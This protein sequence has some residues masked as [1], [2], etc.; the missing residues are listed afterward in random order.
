[1]HTYTHTYTFITLKIA[2]LN[3]RDLKTYKYVKGSKS[4]FFII[5]S[6]HCICS[7]SKNNKLLLILLALTDDLLGNFCSFYKKKSVKTSI[8]N[9][10][11]KQRKK[12]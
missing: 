9:I 6:L 12:F 1:M 5:F 11:E 2:T 7:E 3:S 10:D 8:L 4:N